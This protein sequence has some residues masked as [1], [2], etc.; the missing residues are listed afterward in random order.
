MDLSN[1][2][3]LTR[4]QILHIQ[5]LQ[6]KKHRLDSRTFFIEGARLCEQVLGSDWPVQKIICSENLRPSD[7]VTKVFEHAWRRQIPFCKTKAQDFDKI[8]NTV[9]TQGIGAVVEF[10][11]QKKPLAELLSNENT[12]VCIGIEVLGDPGNL[13]TIIR[14][15]E[16]LGINGLILGKKTVAWHNDK[17]LRASMGA[18]F[19]LPFYQITD[20]P[21][22]LQTARQDGFEIFAADQNA[23]KTL[24][25]VRI[26]T[27]SLLLFGDEAHG[28]SQQT[29]AAAGNHI[30]IPGYGQVESLNV[31]SAAAII[32][33]RFCEDRNG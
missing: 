4:A 1:A 6:R 27:K 16:W 12:K 5:N 2:E 23:K 11:Q 26:P 33:G 30:R 28:L 3:Q 10:N 19:H 7:E 25:Q 29:L 31:A 24:N 18:I 17:V 9:H 13:G 32:M 22:F 20:F 8:S 14:T 15:A 21:N